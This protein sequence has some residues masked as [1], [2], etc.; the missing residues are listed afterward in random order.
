MNSHVF[1]SGI[2]THQSGGPGCAEVSRL[3]AVRTRDKTLESDE[4]PWSLDFT[5]G[6]SWK[7]DTF[8]VAQMSLGTLSQL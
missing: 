2:H 4:Q 1:P 7:P 5:L 3:V 8:F 6:V